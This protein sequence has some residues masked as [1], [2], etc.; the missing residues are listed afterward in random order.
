MH[1]RTHTHARTHTHTHL[2]VEVARAIGNVPL[3]V[4]REERPP[5]VDL[6]RRL[7]SLGIREAVRQQSATARL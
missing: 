6:L 7:R 1:G 4:I 3:R 2:A 5:A